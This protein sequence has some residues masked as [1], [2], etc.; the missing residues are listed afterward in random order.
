MY[1]KQLL[2]NKKK[3]RRVLSNNEFETSTTIYFDPQEYIFL[4][5]SCRTNTLIW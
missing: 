4:L 1:D 2:L 5:L 3:E